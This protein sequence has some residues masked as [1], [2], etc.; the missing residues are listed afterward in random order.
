MERLVVAG[1]GLQE[2]V[3]LALLSLLPLVMLQLKVAVN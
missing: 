3:E 2:M 1:S